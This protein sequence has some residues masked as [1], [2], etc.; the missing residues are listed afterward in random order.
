MTAGVASRLLLIAWRHSHVVVNFVP[1]ISFGDPNRD[2]AMERRRDIYIYSR[3][4]ERTK[5]W[6]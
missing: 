3:K 6:I 1:G 2:A 4:T 5:D